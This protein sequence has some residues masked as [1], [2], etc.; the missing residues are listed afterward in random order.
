[1]R[2]ISGI[3]KGRRIHAPN[4][5]PVRPTTD[6]A[7]E[8]LFNILNHQMY[9][10]NLKV[11]DLFAGTGNISYEFISRGV[12]QATC[13]DKN[14]KCIRFIEQTANALEANIEAIQT[15]VISFLSQH[16]STYD[17]IFADPPYDSDFEIFESMIT[18]ILSKNLLHDGGLLILEHSKQ[19]DLSSLPKYSDSRVYGSCVFSFFKT[20]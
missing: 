20:N 6:R 18:L 19:T 8:A 10:E 3:H 11:L 17:I 15:D 1:M 2:I 9:F 16:R 5:L 7:K 13:V 4:N 14:M 12:H